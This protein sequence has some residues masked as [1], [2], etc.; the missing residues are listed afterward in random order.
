M[1]HYYLQRD[2]AVKKK[3]KEKGKWG[4]GGYVK[5]RRQITHHDVM[6][7]FFNQCGRTTA[8]PDL[9]L[10]CWTSPSV[11]SDETITMGAGSTVTCDVV[12]ASSSTGWLFTGC[13]TFV[14][15]FS[16]FGHSSHSLLSRGWNLRIWTTCTLKWRNV[17]FLSLFWQVLN[18]VCCWAYIIY[19]LE[20]AFVL[21]EKFLR[22]VFF[23]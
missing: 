7:K 11:S 16:S 1:A 22:P 17:F 12:I 6:S 2:F 14:S 8:L 19:N 13:I 10:V 4:G 9:F 15:F 5:Q 21:W 18:Q 20:E 3:K 23:L